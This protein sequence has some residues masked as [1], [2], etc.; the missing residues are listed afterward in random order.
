MRFDKRLEN[1]NNPESRILTRAENNPIVLKESSTGN[2]RIEE[3][4]KSAYPVYESDFDDKDLEV[5]NK[6]NLKPLVGGLDNEV[7]LYDNKGKLFL[8]NFDDGPNVIASTDKYVK[9]L[10]RKIKYIRGSP[11]W[12]TSF[13]IY[14]FFFVFSHNINIS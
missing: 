1:F 13:F 12:I 6:R 9:D 4:L 7:I 5:F 11:Y 14:C 8:Y 10:D 3:I 2:I